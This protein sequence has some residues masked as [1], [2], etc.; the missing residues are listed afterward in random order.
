MASIFAVPAPIKEQV[1]KLNALVE[2]NPQYI[3]VP[4]AARFLGVNPDGLRHSIDSGQCPFG[5]AWQKTLKG[6]KAFK[7]PTLTFYLWVT[8][9]GAMRYASM[10]PDAGILAEGWEETR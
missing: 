1:E 6:N 4:E 7:I 3:P 8:Q 5:I 9:C 10:V 2:A